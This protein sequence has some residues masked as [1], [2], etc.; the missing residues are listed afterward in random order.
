MERESPKTESEAD[1][2]GK[3]SGTAKYVGVPPTLLDS[4]YR[5]TR[6]VD[7]IMNP[8][9]RRLISGMSL[10]LP[11]TK[12]MDAIR[13]QTQVFDKI[14][15]HFAK[16][17]AS[18]IPFAQLAQINAQF[19]AAIDRLSLS[20]NSVLSDAFLPI[21]ELAAQI[22]EVSR[23]GDAFRHYNLW[24]APSMSEELVAKIV[25]LYESG[26]NSGTVHSVVSRYYAKDNWQ[27]LEQVLERCRNN[28]LFKRR[29]KVIEEALRAHKEGLYNLSVPGL[30]IHLEG[31]AA[32][33]VKK[34]NLLPQVGG[35][36]KEIIVTALEDTPYSL[37]D[38]RTY[39]GVDALIEYVEDSMFA[40]VDFDKEH[41]RLHGENKLQ[42]HAVRHGRQ[43]AFGSRMNSLRL[44][45]FVD[46]MTLLKD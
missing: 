10:T 21:K 17:I 13:T 36:T 35:Q 18:S 7:S 31:I 1:Y 46:V 33:Y 3:M 41:V 23:V 44:F 9:I 14:D 30:L 5:Q 34:H 40:Y 12:I 32:D 22:G 28:P 24:L 15:R 11:N 42:G 6:M 29:I 20:V 19:Q 2:V 25:S 37:L 43:V 8:A 39:A 27:R 45:L 4:I 16:V 38:L 26:A